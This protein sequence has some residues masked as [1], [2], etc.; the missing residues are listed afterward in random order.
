MTAALSRDG[1]EII[2]EFF[3]ATECDELIEA[4]GRIAKDCSLSAGLRNLLRDCPSV[5]NWASAPRLKMLIR[6]HLPD[7]PFAVRALFFDKT[8]QANWRVAWHQD[9]TI[10]VTRRID[11]DGFGPW[12]MKSGVPHVQAPAT[13]LAQM[14]T[15]RLHLDDCDESNGA[16]K[17]IPKSHRDGK[18]SSNAIVAWRE[19]SSVVTCTVK[20]GGVLLMRPLLLHASSS[21]VRA[22][23]R[24]VVHVEYAGANLPGGLRW[25]EQAGDETRMEYSVAF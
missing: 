9:L 7:E 13:M 6:S 5:T 21:A 23:H 11:V 3:T 18:L 20:R 12:S 16:L 2:P 19:S 22:A 17:V 8:Q 4:I 25:Y 15:V 14:V 10:A 24:R 1:F